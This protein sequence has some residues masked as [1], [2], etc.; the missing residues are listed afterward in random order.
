MNIL[1]K[2]VTGEPVNDGLIL[3]LSRAG[4]PSGSVVRGVAFSEANN[5]CYWSRG[6]DY[7]IAYLGETCQVLP[8]GAKK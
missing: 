7:C 4:F 8:L 1:I 5:S 2:N 3:E 6:N